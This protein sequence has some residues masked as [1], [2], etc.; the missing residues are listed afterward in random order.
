MKV[1]PR[2]ST[3]I[4]GVILGY[5]TLDKPPYGLGHRPTD[6]THYFEE[7][8]VHLPR[9]EIPRRIQMRREVD[10]WAGNGQVDMACTVREGIMH[11]EEFEEECDGPCAYSD[12]DSFTL[13]P[14]EQAMVPAVWSGPVPECDYAC[15]EWPCIDPD[16][17]VLPG[18]C[19]GGDREVM[20]CIENS[21]LNP[22]LVES[23][24]SLAI[25]R[26]PPEGVKYYRKG[27][28]L[29]GLSLIHI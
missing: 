22:A 2:G 6:H 7:L 16:V 5:P 28:S 15:E 21:S 29:L 9:A 23:G 10:S 13:Q 27:E 19:A 24:A 25:A 20:L 11:L 17:T 14:G 1:L 4:P 18:L 12:A 26:L 8:G 3:A